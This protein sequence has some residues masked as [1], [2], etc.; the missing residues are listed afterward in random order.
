MPHWHSQIHFV[1]AARRGDYFDETVWGHRV[2][3]GSC[4]G[5]WPH[6]LAVHLCRQQSYLHPC[7][8]SSFTPV[9]GVVPQQLHPTTIR[10]Y[11]CDVTFVSKEDLRRLGLIDLVFAGWPC[12]GHSRAGAGRGLEDP[13]S[14]L[15]WDLI[16][17]MQWWFTHQPFTPGYIFDNVPL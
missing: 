8:K 6:C 15:Y 4:V 5:S 9:D 16:Q 13:R 10:D 14:S 3:I 12:L 1:G 7:D 11:H 2:G 17:P